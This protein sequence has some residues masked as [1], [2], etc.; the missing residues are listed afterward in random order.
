MPKTKSK[1]D[2]KIETEM[3]NGRFSLSTGNAKGHPLYLDKTI[4]PTWDE[5]A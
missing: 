1:V 3:L 5:N 4:G 2:L